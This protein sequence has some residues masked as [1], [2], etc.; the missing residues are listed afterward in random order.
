LHAPHHVHAAPVVKI[1]GVNVRANI[2]ERVASTT[3]EVALH[4]PSSGRVN[5]EVVLPIPDGAAVRGFTFQGAGSEPTAELLTKEQA[6][7]IYESLVAKVRDPALLEFVGFQLL[8]SSVFPVE[9]NA[10]QKVQL[11]YEE[12]LPADGER[13]DYVLP[14]SETADPETHWSVKVAV[15]SRDPIAAVYSPSHGLETVRPSP[16]EVQVQMAAS[17][18]REPGPF[19]LSILR[20]RNEGVTASFLAYPDPKVGG[21]YFLLMAAAPTIPKQ[22]DAKLRREVTLVIDKSGSMAGEKIEQAREAG[23]QILGGLEEG[24]FFNLISFESSVDSFASEPVPATKENLKAGRD[25]L[26]RIRAGGGTNLH[27]ALVASLRPE[28]ARGA[29]PLVLFLTD[30]LPTVGVTQ[31]SAIRDLAVKGN[32]YGRRVLTF[33]VGYD[34]NAP[35][36]DKI[37]AETRGSAV[38]VAPKED[39]E[40]KV[41]GVFR[42]LAGP[43]LADPVLHTSSSRADP[44]V[45]ILDAMPARLPDLFDGDQL[46]VLGKYSSESRIAMTLEGNFRGTVRSFQFDFD[47][48][49]ASIKNAFVP[50][51]W[52]ARKIALLIDAVRQ[53]GGGSGGA[54]LTRNDPRVKELVDEIVR[55]SKEFGVLT[56]YTAFLARE[57]TNLSKTDEL[58]DKAEHELYRRAVTVRSGLGAVNQG[59]NLNGQANA[60]ALNPSNR[61]FDAE[62][63]E[64]SVTSVR[65]VADRAFYRRSGRWVDGRVLDDEKKQAPTRVIEFGSDAFRALAGRLATEGRQGT[66]ALDGDIVLLVDGEPTLIRGP[67]G[68]KE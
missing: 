37:A 29:L 68:A 4:N 40:V 1:T 50:R 66:I 57:G 34:V 44:R 12:V 47:P 21:G 67:A 48:T 5:A 51:L 27:D 58:R 35:L 36:L 56:E 53:L 31:E 41:A 25:Y 61:F 14:R 54:A 30:G 60:F 43:V 13:I 65:Q 11:V 33:G 49:A 10:D 63:K 45:R 18:T 9:P 16:T 64:A 46:V 7:S 2:L 23:M 59:I 15:R 6:K 19:R 55:L 8:R 24:E 38:Y 22:A 28:P 17:A 52:A 26:K 62:M 20:G 3:V 39:V 32:K 42:R